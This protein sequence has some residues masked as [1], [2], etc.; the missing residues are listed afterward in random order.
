MTMSPIAGLS[1]ASLSETLSWSPCPDDPRVI[2]ALEAYLERRESGGAVEIES[3]LGQH[4]SIAA[5]L[6]TAIE[7]VELLMGGPSLC[8]EMPAGDGLDLRSDLGD[9]EIVRELG[10][11]GMGVVYEAHQRSLR[12]R[13]AIKVL[14][15]GA[16]LDR[17][18][19]LRFQHEAQT[20]AQLQHPSIV[21]VHA[22]GSEHGLPFYVMRYIDGPNLGDVIDR[23]RQDS[24]GDFVEASEA[25]ATEWPATPEVSSLAYH[26]WVA[27]IGR[28]ACE[29]LDHAHGHG[30]VHRDV[31]PGN[32]LLDS[33]GRL[34]ITDFGLARWRGDAGMT[35][36]G[37]LVGTL[38]YMSPEQAL[39]RATV[40]DG[41]SDVYSLGATL[42]ELLTLQP[43][44]AG[45]DAAELLSRI[46]TETP[47][48]PRRH[49]P[50]LPRAL[51]TIV[52]KAMAKEPDRRYAS[53]L[54][55]GEDLGRFLRHEPIAARRPGVLERAGGW[56]RRHRTAARVGLAGL[57]LVTGSLAGG[58]CMLW[59]GMEQTRRALMTESAERAR[60][61]SNF[62]MA[63]E[64]IDSMVVREA[65]RKATETPAPLPHPADGDSSLRQALDFYE[66]FVTQNAGNPAVQRH[67]AEAHTRIADLR[68]ELGDLEAAEAA[69]DRAREML[70]RLAQQF[71]R[72]MSHRFEL[73]M[74]Q[75]NLGVLLRDR[76]R[77]CDS[78][79]SLREAHELLV[80]L[81]RDLPRSYETERRLA[82]VE[83]NLG[84]VL[85]STNQLEA[86][87]EQLVSALSRRTMLLDSPAASTDLQNDLALTHASLGALD[88]MRE[89]YGSAEASFAESARLLTDL[90]ER[91]PLRSE[92]RRNL[93]RSLYNQ[94][95]VRSETGKGA[96][97]APLADRAI[98]LQR[99]LMG[100]FPG[101]MDLVNDLAFSACARGHIQAALDNPRDAETSFREAVE[102]WELLV[103]RSPEMRV[104][105]SRALGAHLELAF[106]HRDQGHY[107]EAVSEFRAV[108][109]GQ[110]QNPVVMNDLAWFLGSDP[111]ATPAA[112]REALDLARR[113][114]TIRD[115]LA[116]LWNTLG[117]ILYH[118]G[119]LDEAR[120][121]IERSMR[122]N[123]G[124][125][126]FDWLYLARLAH[127]RDDRLEARICYERAG[128]WLATQA[129][130]DPEF[131]SLRRAVAGELALE[132]PRTS[133]SGL[134]GGPAC[135]SG[136]GKGPTSIT[137]Q[138]L[139]R[140]TTMRTMGS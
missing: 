86:A 128:S 89:R 3:F 59:R 13:V 122:L 132:M 87:R 31:K 129:G 21:P 52:L 55:M 79:L 51:E 66:R 58:T 84:V 102:R 48:A 94:A 139:Q 75:N 111:A 42:Y 29:A 46:A 96:E 64:A 9:F 36:S 112:R 26:R 93:G 25:G 70:N 34:W 88:R 131:E 6:R 41:R 77:L 7:G 120:S 60:A 125:D 140:L 114:V 12:R 11:G 43:V 17:R 24:A 44:L 133:A 108:L 14:P 137:S 23:L 38:R 2:D 138:T 1:E 127:R 106:L 56:A 83:H 130:S 78:E 65:E 35:V 18:Q 63:R 16:L 113:A 53:A 71:P 135:R 76:G 68:A 40:L 105:A 49:V 33:K 80:Q 116:P 103:R 37:D 74:T 95:L 124:G 121:A 110:P 118:E 27:E 100:Q 91:M 119:Q 72:V 47:V 57:V 32:L 123:G 82:V 99:E 10:R 92:F 117:V 15:P 45:R 107:D 54:A 101:R 73:A 98:R 97:A 20:A 109:K 39:G 19:C 50:R 81:T 126:G 4:A 115:D 30:V 5:T 28:Q 136:R 85:T 22:I 134:T 8:G 67:S 104:F 62:V 69:Y 90:V 61:E